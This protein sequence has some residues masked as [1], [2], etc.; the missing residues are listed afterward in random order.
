MTKRK[1]KTLLLIFGIIFTINMI[2]EIGDAFI[3]GAWA[4]VVGQILIL[5]IFAFIAYKNRDSLQVYRDE[6]RE[7]F[8]KHTDNIGVKDAA[9]FSLTWSKEIYERIPEDRKKLVK[10]SFVLIGVAFVVILFEV[11]FSQLLTIV[12]CAALVLAGVNLLVW[13]VS[14]ERSDK[15]VLSV[16]LKTARDMQMSLMPKTDTQFAGFDISGFCAPALNVGGDLFDYFSLCQKK[17]VLGIAV[18]DVAGKGM[19]AA[20]TAVFTSGALVSET[21]HEASP[22]RIMENLNRT[23]CTRQNKQKFVSLLLAIIDSSQKQISIV[24]AGQSKPLLSRRNE[25]TVI[26]NE[27]TRF[28]LGVVDQCMYTETIFPLQ[29]GDIFLFYTDGL[30]EAMNVLLEPFGM[31]RLQRIFKEAVRDDADSKKIIHDVRR[32]IL[33]YTGNAEQSDDMTMVVVKVS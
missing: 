16:E 18:A 31:E 27:G 21:Q 3:S 8:E 17:D 14:S 33:F 2:D 22:A 6:Y 19:E 10:Q 15:D 25:V 20:L 5:S 32:Q 12:I 7:K 1:Q 4:P 11:G 28:P 29:H 24:N 13:V 30:T 26:E 23:I 9:L